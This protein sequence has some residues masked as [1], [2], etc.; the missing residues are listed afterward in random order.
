M[1][2]QTSKVRHQGEI[3]L[4][5]GIELKEVMYRPSFNHNLMSVQ[6]LTEHEKCKVI[7]HAGHC[8][9]EDSVTHTVRGLGLADKGLY[10]LINEPIDSVIKK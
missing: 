8:V 2:K 4:K 3:Q 10:Y 5:S 7:F 6:K 9:I 1:V